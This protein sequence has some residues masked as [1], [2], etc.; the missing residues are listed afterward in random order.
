M[1]LSP[2]EQL[3]RLE[4]PTGSLRMVL[5]TDTYNEIDDQFAVAYALL[6][7]ERLR[8]E[9]LYAAPFHNSRSSGPDDGMEKS[10]NEI[11][12][13]LERLARPAAGF[14]L[15]G[16]TG[17][18]TGRQQ[19]EQSPAALDLVQ[20]AMASPP[21]DLLYVVAIGA[22]TNVA[23][24][25]LLEPEITRRIVVVWLGGQPHALHFAREFNLMQDRR[26]SQ[27]IFDCGVPLIQ[28]PCLGVASH[29]L[30]TVPELEQVLK[31]RN[32]VSEFLFERFCEYHHDHFAWAKEIWD[33][34]AI[35]CLLNSEWVPTRVVPSPVLSDDLTWITPPA[36]RHSIRTAW[37]VH[38]NPIFADL[39]R[40]LQY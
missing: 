6:S 28:I 20:R 11:M 24:A 23:S 13:L 1:N 3:K 36:R 39:F 2:E 33:I 34:S 38:R 4:F 30:T 37:F 18:L 17:W 35:A 16:S 14:V 26:A 29:L 10:Y 22:I 21:D 40:K 25:I 19:P 8:V 27:L 12:R 31:G 32:P 9:A 5:D 15:R 7:P